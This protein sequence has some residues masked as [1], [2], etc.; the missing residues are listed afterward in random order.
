MAERAAPCCPAPQ[1]LDLLSR[2]LG[3]LGNSDHDMAKGFLDLAVKLM[4]VRTPGQG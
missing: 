3:A 2:M 4:Q 1:V